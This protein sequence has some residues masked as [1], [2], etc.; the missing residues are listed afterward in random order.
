[1][2]VDDDI[3]FVDTHLKRK[4]IGTVIILAVGLYVIFAPKP[5]LQQDNISTDV[6]RGGS[7]DSRSLM[8]TNADIYTNGVYVYGKESNK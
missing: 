3:K 8:P 5:S 6:V 4:I 1:M 2:N 7:A